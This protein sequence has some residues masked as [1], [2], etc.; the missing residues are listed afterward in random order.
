MAGVDVYKNPSAEQIEGAIGGLVNLRTAMPFDYKGLKASGSVQGTY[1]ELKKGKV[2]PSY[3]ALLS[4]RWTTGAGEIGALFD[5]AYSESG[6]RT[7]AF[8]VEPYYPRTDVVPGKTVW[9]PKG[10]Q[11]RTLLFDRKRFGAYGALQWRPNEDLTTSLTL[12][13]S[14]YKMKWDE[15]AIFAQSSPY[16]IQV[17]SDATYDSEGALLPGTISDPADGCINFG[18]DT[19]TATRESDTTDVAWNLSWNVS[20]KLTLHS[21]LQYVRSRTGS[22]DSTVATSVPKP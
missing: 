6:T 5:V 8:Q 10:A 16:N 14:H 3:S 1:S 4:D 12:F 2:D 15:A 21:D 22:F 20:D 18:D 7:D 13:N 9:I 19:R 11:W 17:S